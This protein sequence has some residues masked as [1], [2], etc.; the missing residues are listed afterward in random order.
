MSDKHWCY[1]DGCASNNKNGE[2]THPDYGI[3]KQPSSCECPKCE[4]NK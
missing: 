2:C 3:K 4:C 1:N